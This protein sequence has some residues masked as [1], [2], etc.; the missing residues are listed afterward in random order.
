MKDTTNKH[1]VKRYFDTYS[2]K[3]YEFDTYEEAVEFV[4]NKNKEVENM[5]KTC[6]EYVGI[7]NKEK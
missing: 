3:E 1:L 7:I 5:P 4:R 2:E 6:F